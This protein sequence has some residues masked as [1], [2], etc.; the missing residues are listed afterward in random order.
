MVWCEKKGKVW[1]CTA[2]SQKAQRGCECFTGS[3]TEWCLHQGNGG[4]CMSAEARKTAAG[5]RVYD[6]SE[7][8]RKK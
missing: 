8:S 4:R 5:D 6:C 7:W 3:T 2:N 1:R